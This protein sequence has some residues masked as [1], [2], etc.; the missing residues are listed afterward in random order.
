MLQFKFPLLALKGKLESVKKEG[1]VPLF[2]VHSVHVPRKKQTTVKTTGL[3]QRSETG[4]L[5]T[6]VSG[7][8]SAA[9]FGKV[10]KMTRCSEQGA[11]VT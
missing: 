9:N 4:T 10:R 7:L 2:N 11:T 8:R 6:S 5:Q 1:A 3:R